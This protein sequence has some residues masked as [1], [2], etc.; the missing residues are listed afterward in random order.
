MLRIFHHPNYDFIKW[1]RWAAALTVGWIVIGLASY[2]VRPSLNWSIEFLGGTLMQLEFNTPPHVDELRQTLAAAGIGGT[3]IQ[4]F[5]SEREFT[6]RAQDH[7]EA[8]ARN[9]GGAA[10]AGTSG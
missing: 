9:A 4:E 1:W 7:G 8:A 5:G 6:V 10:S 2:A 3:E